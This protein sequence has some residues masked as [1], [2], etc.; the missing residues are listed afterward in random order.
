VREAPPPQFLAARDVADR[1]V[2]RLFCFQQYVGKLAHV[3]TFQVSIPFSGRFN[4]TT[5]AT[6]D[7]CLGALQEA[8]A[9]GIV[10][11]RSEAAF[12]FSEFMGVAAHVYRRE[13]SS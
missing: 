3:I 1:F 12:A 9:I 2:V 8:V 7:Y 11:E 10:F 4:P 6:A 5:R 13:S